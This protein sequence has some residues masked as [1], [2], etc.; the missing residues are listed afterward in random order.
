MDPISGIANAVGSIFN[1]GANI[2]MSKTRRLEARVKDKENLMLS[3]APGSGLTLNLFEDDSSQNNQI[4]AVL[5]VVL[6][7]I[8]VGVVFLKKSKA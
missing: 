4:I 2:S 5:G 1:F 3:R 8:L 6:V 7:I